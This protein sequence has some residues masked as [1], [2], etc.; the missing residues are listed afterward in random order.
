M[1]TLPAPPARSR[2]PTRARLHLPA[3]A[4]LAAAGCAAGL[5]E[6]GDGGHDGGAGSGAPDAVRGASP[7]ATAA[8]AA[9]P[10]DGAPGCAACAPCEGTPWGTVAHGFAGTAYARPVAIYGTTCASTAEVR[11]C[12]DGALS[13][14]YGSATCADYPCEWG[15]AWFGHEMAAFEGP[16]HPSVFHVCGLDGTW[17]A[18]V[19]GNP[20][21]L[22]TP[23]EWQERWFERSTCGA[24]DGVTYRCQDG[25]WVDA[26]SCPAP[27]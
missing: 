3:A 20:V 15:G 16:T 26:P 25:A 11:T 4:A 1:V 14:T 6:P 8:D 13:G 12:T 19:P 23:C 10:P 2:R 18:G 22:G 27:P 21:A 17:G 9:P 5:G 24:L 7:D